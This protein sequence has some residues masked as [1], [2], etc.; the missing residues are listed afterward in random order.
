[1][2]LIFPP[3]EKGGEGGFRR[4]SSKN[5]PKSPFTKGGFYK[6]YQASGE[7]RSNMGTDVEAIYQLMM[8][9]VNDFRKKT[10]DLEE[11]VTFC[12]KVLQ[13]QREV[14]AEISVPPVR[15]DRAHL[16]VKIS[17]GFPLLSREDFF[18]DRE[19]SAKLLE[20]LCR[21]GLGENP[22]LADGSKHLLEAMDSGGV[23][24]E[25]LF[26]A[27]VSDDEAG[28]EALAGELKIPRAVLKAL[29]KLS[30][31]PSLSASAAAATREVSLEGWNRPHCG[32]CGGLPAM[33]ALV[34]EEGRRYGLCSF[35]GTLYRLPRVGCP[36][37][38]TENPDDLRYFY[39]EDEDLYR[40][41]VCDRCSGYLKVL[42]TRKGG[43][44][45][46]LA[47]EDI[48]T[49]HLD[50]IAEEQGYERKVPR[51]WGI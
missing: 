22:V 2:R 39:G 23:N 25:G 42:D 48:L 10:P 4:Q 26:A 33:A 21:I 51:L 15:L 40:V 18:V 47:V 7:I 30:V 5:P 16:A 34:G 3:F 6:D 44:V 27:V 45:E 11:I 46:A 1:M 8:E 32:V 28:L 14:Q 13:A 17:E 35:C 31:Q 37:C 24:L 29:A 41:Q 12:E 49:A 19:R 50:L 43:L 38:G 9:R 20:R 36:F